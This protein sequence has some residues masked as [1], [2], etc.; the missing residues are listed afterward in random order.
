MA[1]HG[2]PGIG[3]GNDQP[4]FGA[5]IAPHFLAELDSSTATIIR[6]KNA[7]PAA[8][9]RPQIHFLFPVLQLVFAET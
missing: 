5:R 8:F 4:V 3:L 1:V 2:R 9:D 7:K 6:A